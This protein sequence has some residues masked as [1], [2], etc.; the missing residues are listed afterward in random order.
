MP[1]SARMPTP[2]SQSR[3]GNKADAHEDHL[4][5]HASIW[6]LHLQPCVCPHDF[7][8]N[9]E[10][11]IPRCCLPFQCDCYLVLALIVG[12]S[13]SGWKR[14]ASLSPMPGLTALQ[15]PAPTKQAIAMCISCMKGEGPRQIKSCT[16]RYKE[17]LCPISLSLLIPRPSL[18]DIEVVK[19]RL[20]PAS[21][22]PTPVVNCGPG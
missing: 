8:I 6:H 21:W 10:Q 4:G 9:R 5:L 14:L 15:E 22:T 2:R 13:D 1:Q 11:D 20:D 3:V 7:S 12:A 17:S 16:S 18:A 19:S